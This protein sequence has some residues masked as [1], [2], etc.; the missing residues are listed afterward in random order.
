MNTN[1]PTAEEFVH[2][3]ADELSAGAA[4]TAFVGRI[5]R[6]RITQATLMVEAGECILILWAINHWNYT[7]LTGR[8]VL[9]A[10]AEEAAIYS[11]HSL[12]LAAPPRVIIARI[13]RYRRREAK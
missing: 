1:S 6:T 4:R 2:F 12:G 11:V 9:A 8:R 3:I 10:I 13:N 5:L 7:V